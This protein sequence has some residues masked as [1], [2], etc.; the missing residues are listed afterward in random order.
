MSGANWEV[1]AIF[2][3]LLFSAASRFIGVYVLY[4]SRRHS[5]NAAGGS[6]ELYITSLTLDKLVGFWAAAWTPVR[7]SQQ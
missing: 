2:I 1:K 7:G 6:S 3:A 4:A 5:S